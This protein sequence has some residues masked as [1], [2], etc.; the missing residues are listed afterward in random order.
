[1][2]AKKH[3]GMMRW[4]IAYQTGLCYDV[5]GENSLKNHA[6][7]RIF[8]SAVCDTPEWRLENRRNGRY[9]KRKVKYRLGRKALLLAAAALLLYGSTA[10]GKQEEAVTEE[11]SREQIQTPA[12]EQGLIDLQELTG[13]ASVEGAGVK[14]TTGGYDAEPQTVKTIEELMELAADNVPR[15][16]VIDGTLICQTGQAVEVGSNK[17]IV[18]ADAEATLAGGF[19]IRN[20]ANVIISN[21]QIKREQTGIKDGITA[22]AS[23]HLWFDHLSIQDASDGLLDVTMGSDFTTVSWCKFFYEGGVGEHRLSCLVG[24]GTGHDE[25]DMG[26]L[27]VTYHHNWFADHCDQRMPRILYGKGHVYN[28]YYTCSGNTYCVGVASYASVL[29]ENNYFKEVNNPHQFMYDTALPAS[30]TARGNIYDATEGDEDNGAGGVA[31]GYVEPFTEPP[32]AYTLDEA[33]QVPQIVE[34]GAGPRN[35]D[36]TKA[37]DGETEEA[38]DTYPIT[39]DAET[40]TYTYNGNNRDRSHASV[41]IANPFAGLDLGEEAGTEG[42]PTWNSGVTISYW[43]KLSTGVSDAAILNFN[44][45]GKRRINNMDEWKYDLCCAYT[46]DDADYAMGE[47]TTYIDKEGNTYTVLADAGRYVCFNPDYPKTGCYRAD[48]AAGVIYAYEKGTDSSKESNWKYL[49]WLGEGQY[50]GYHARFDEKGG[51]DSLISEAKINGSLSLYA[52]GTVGFRE[53]DGTGLELNENLP[54]YGKPV[55]IQV[56]NQYYYWGNGSRYSLKGSDLQVPVA[57][58]KNTWHFVTVVIQNDHIQYY[59]DGIKLTNEYLNWWG[60]PIEEEENVGGAAFNMGYGARMHGR[61]NHPAAIFTTGHSI[62]D[63]ITDENTKLYVGG[64]GFGA[65]ALGQDDLGTPSGVQVR[66]LRFYDTVIPENQIKAD[67]IETDKTPLSYMQ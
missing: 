30:I 7:A 6:D 65:E 13:F 22:Y 19:S 62:L 21:L 27:N 42:R 1:M 16:L 23:H 33:D 51:E 66:E 52:T 53:D 24:S 34:A 67:K 39:Y 63:V 14:T 60:K 32:Y 3:K 17:T 29:I 2:Y 61:T 31:Y 9:M 25:T 38:G 59:M 54:G 58:E 43:V 20:A 4:M 5:T 26:K 12:E 49:T 35:A 37:D 41:E 18:G 28:N 55:Q 56:Y 50:E 40:E 36:G 46:K 47:E 48:D 44:L 10:C 64:E 57:A 45:E 11:E 15:V 8:H